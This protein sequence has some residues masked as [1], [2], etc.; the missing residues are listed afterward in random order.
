M[1]LKNMRKWTLN[2]IVSLLLLLLI[3]KGCT[4]AVFDLTE[5]TFNQYTRDKDV[6]LVM[7]FMPW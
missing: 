5:A 7:F 6:M 4:Q 3:D 2:Y 1:S